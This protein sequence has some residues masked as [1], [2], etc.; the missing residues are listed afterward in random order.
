MLT[1]LVCV[2]PQYCNGGDLA[3]YLQG[4]HDSNLKH[5]LRLLMVMK[6]LVLQESC[7]DTVTFLEW[8]QTRAC[9]L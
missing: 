6:F 9:V 1:I 3:D 4:R 8:P 5:A 7:S 2:F